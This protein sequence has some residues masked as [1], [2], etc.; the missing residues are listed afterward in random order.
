[1]IRPTVATLASAEA[2]VSHHKRSNFDNEKL[3]PKV[4]Y[5]YTRVNIG[6]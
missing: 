1:M 6:R 2:G 3:K 4:T 5:Q